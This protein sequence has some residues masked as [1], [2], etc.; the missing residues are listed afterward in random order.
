MDMTNESTNEEWSNVIEK[1][2]KA[3]P[4]S[5]PQ[6]K[7][8]GLGTPGFAKS[9]DHTL[10]KLD[11]TKHQI[12]ELCEEAREHNFKVS[13]SHLLPSSILS[14]AVVGTTRS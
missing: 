14:V 10:L 8:P 11:A 6:Y 5:F 3:V 2:E 13:R 9:I 7:A 1:A 4:S 12:E